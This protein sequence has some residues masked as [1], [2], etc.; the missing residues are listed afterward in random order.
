L[1]GTRTPATSETSGPKILEIRRRLGFTQQMMTERLGG[2]RS[3]LR[4]GHISEFESGKREP[5]LHI[6]LGY[7]RLASVPLEL[8]ADDG[9]DLPEVED[10]NPRLI[11]MR[12][13][14]LRPTAES[15]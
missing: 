5:P 13:P 4:T 2:E 8:L 6:L 14:I 10:C 9:L 3:S 12:G 11:S 7:A 1:N 15:P